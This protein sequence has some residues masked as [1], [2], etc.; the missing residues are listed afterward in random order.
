MIAVC[1]LVLFVIAVSLTTD[2]PLFSVLVLAD[3][4]MIPGT[5]YGVMCVL[6]ARNLDVYCLRA[7]GYR[8]CVFVYTMFGLCICVFVYTIC[9]LCICVFEPVKSYSFH[10]SIS[11]K[12]IQ[13]ADCK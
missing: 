4:C 1:L 10:T 5:V 13:F 3:V 11:S 12:C 8:I 7:F 2:K 9:G 6:Y